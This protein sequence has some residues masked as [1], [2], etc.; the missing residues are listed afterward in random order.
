VTRL[1]R[2]RRR[3]LRAREWQWLDYALAVFLV[4]I[5]IVAT[6]DAHGAGDGPLWANLAMTLVP[7]AAVV[8]RRRRP[9]EVYV[10]TFTIFG[11]A[12]VW[13]LGA[14]EVVS[15]FFCLLFLPYS[16]GAWTDRSPGWLVLAVATITVVN[17][18]GDTLVLGDF[19]FPSGFLIASFAA[20]R[21]VR[22]RTRLAAELHEAAILAEEAHARSTQEA[23][24]EERRR[25]AREMH[26]I[27]AHSVSVMVVQAGGARRIL[28]R[29]PERAEEAA[30]QI[31]RIGRETLA[32]MRRLLGLF[33][34][35]GGVATRAPQ[36]GLADLEALVRR[37]RE[38][39]LPVELMVH[40]DR[41]VLPSGLD[42]TAYRI[43]QEALTNAIKH[44]PG[45]PTEVALRY[46]GDE[47]AL[48]VTNGAP[49]AGPPAAADAVPSGGHGLVGMRE[50][51]KTFGGTATALP[52]GDGGFEV[53][54]RLPFAGD[55]ERA[56]YRLTAEAAA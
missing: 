51:A 26:D 32:E 39:G 21:A 7:G 55:D 16:L 18:F 52:T 33:H 30:A 20:G 17:L 12:P 38:A 49:P 48:R 46:A 36:P 5:G 2:W 23:L 42:L 6:L 11:I 13:L 37:A 56:G 1:H 9:F 8:L 47:L 14:D 25:I 50:R 31:Q 44:A 53:R 19:I 28:A 54:A 27:V 41:R 4:G 29:D 10:A 24:A 35:E 34:T 45:A 43:L 22:T 40:G 15:G 3:G